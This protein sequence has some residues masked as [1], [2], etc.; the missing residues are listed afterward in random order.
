MLLWAI[1]AVKMAIFHGSIWAS[2]VAVHAIL[3]DQVV[4]CVAREMV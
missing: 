2:V 3:R 1:F 4:V